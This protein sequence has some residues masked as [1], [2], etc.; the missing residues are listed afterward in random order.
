MPRVTCELFEYG[1][2][3]L[4]RCVLRVGEFGCRGL[5]DQLGGPRPSPQERT[6]A[7]AAVRT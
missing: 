7:A 4:R 2:R 1:F 5:D 3:E 6:S